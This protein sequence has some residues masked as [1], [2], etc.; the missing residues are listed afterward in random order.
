RAFR[1]L[2]EPPVSLHQV[3]PVA[4]RVRGGESDTF[5]PINRIDRLE[6]LH[7]WRLAL[8]DGNLAPAV[9]GDNLSQQR[10]LLHAARDQFPALG[11]DLR[12]RPAALLPAS[13]R[14]D[15]ERAVLI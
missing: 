11:H 14:H 6:Q 9:T 12:D 8:P 7:E 13:V 3:I 2:A 1:Q 10:N 4:F 15:T 5:Q